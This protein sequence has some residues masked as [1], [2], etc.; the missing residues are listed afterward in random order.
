MLTA[1]STPFI[2]PL[3]HPS[4]HQLPPLRPPPTCLMSHCFP[5]IHSSNFLLPSQIELQVPKLQRQTDTHIDARRHAHTQARTHAYRLTLI[6]HR[7]K[8]P[9]TLSQPQTR[10]HLLLHASYA[11]IFTASPHN[12]ITYTITLSNSLSLS[13][14]ISLSHTHTHTHTHTH[15]CAR[16]H[17]HTHCLAP[18]RLLI[19]FRE[20]AVTKTSSEATDGPAREKNNKTPKTLPVGGF[21]HMQLIHT[22]THTVTHEPISP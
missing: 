22:L 4:L 12:L 8:R 1:T 5:L 2:S 17:T 16:A 18:T 9:Q 14:S 10:T 11:I 13:L 21:A 7:P 3:C 19:R 15:A 20:R 6:T